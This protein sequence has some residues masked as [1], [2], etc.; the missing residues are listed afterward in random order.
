M[1]DPATLGAISIGGTVLGGLLNA[2]GAAQQAGAQA[3][4]Y[5][6][7]AGIAE[8]NKQIQ[9]QNRDYALYA[10]EREA[11]RFG[12]QA[13]QR[14]GT[15]AATRSASGFDVTSGSNADVLASDRDMARRDVS[16]IRQNAARVAYGYATEAAGQDLQAGLYRKAAADTLAGKKVSVASSLLSTA[17]SVSSKWLQGKQMGLWGGD[18]G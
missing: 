18:N 9:L 12:I 13:R 14:Q 6:Y 17:T 5:Q 1:A 16:T 10:G 8:Y 11:E 4:T 15:L 3:S 2:K 7:Q